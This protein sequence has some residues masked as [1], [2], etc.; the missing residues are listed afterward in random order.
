MRVLI[1]EDDKV[2]SD[3][4]SRYL[5]QSG[6]VVDVASNGTAADA[7]LATEE[8]ALWYWTSGCPAWT[9]S[10]SCGAYGGAKTICRC[11]S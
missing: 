3:G 2:L 9:A 5:Q 7:M 10:R 1:V 8:L 11:W 4:L 6:Y